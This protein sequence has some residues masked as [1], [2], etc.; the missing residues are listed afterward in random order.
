MK[1][2]EAKCRA[3][4]NL[5][6]PF[7]TV[8]K[9]DAT[10]LYWEP[11]SASVSSVNFKHQPIGSCQWFLLA[12]SVPPMTALMGAKAGI[13][14]RSGREKPH[15]SQVRQIVKTKKCKGATGHAPITYKSLDMIWCAYQVKCLVCSCENL[16]KRPER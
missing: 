7:T 3:I 2:W 9:F 4:V 11:A 1:E 13:H 15:A 8:E 16:P 12:M 10:T 14:R 5:F 6:A